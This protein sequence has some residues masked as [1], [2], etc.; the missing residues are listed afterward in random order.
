MTISSTV[1]VTQAAQSQA[2]RL[3]A[4]LSDVRQGIALRELW[5]Y[6]GWRDVQKHYRRSVLGPLWLTLS[7]GITVGGLGFLYAQIFQMEIST[8]LP[9]LALGFI[10]WGLIAGSLNGACMVFS[11]AAASIRQIRLPLSVHILQF[12]WSQ[13]IAFGHNFIIY[14]IVIV[15]FG[16]NPG[17]NAVLFI[18]ALCLLTLNCVFVCMILGP[19]CARFRDIPMI[20][21]SVTQVA[22]FMTPILWSAEQLPERAHFVQLNP[23][24]HFIE[25]SRGPL[26]GQ[27]VDPTNWVAAIGMTAAIGVVAILFFARFRA[28]VAYWA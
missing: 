2:E 8:Y 28:R 26:L 13:L 10:V 21:A 12:A 15:A 11:N 17:W 27:A 1:S 16:L 4:L 18:P 3:S 9:S 23:F 22:F 5:L 14:L 6:L 19:F 7:M 20:V 25:I 24:Y